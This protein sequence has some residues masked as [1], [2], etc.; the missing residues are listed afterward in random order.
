MS[1][2]N[3]TQLECYRLLKLLHQL[4]LQPPRI[5]HDEHLKAA[6]FAACEHIDE[7]D[8][9]IE[10]LA[11]CFNYILDVL[12][13]ALI[14]G[15]LPHYFRPGVNL[16]ADISEDFMIDLT[17]K[18]SEIR[19]DPL[20]FLFRLNPLT[21]T[22][23]MKPSPNASLLCHVAEDQAEEQGDKPDIKSQQTD[24]KPQMKQPDNASQPDEITM[25]DLF[26]D[27]VKDARQFNEEEKQIL[28]VFKNCYE[29]LILV[30]I[31]QEW[32]NEA[33]ELGEEFIER[34][35]PDTIAKWS[36]LCNLALS[37]LEDL[38][39]IISFLELLAEQSDGEEST[40]LQNLACMY[41]SLMHIAQDPEDIKE[42][43]AKTDDLFKQAM[44]IND[45][46]PALY[47][48]YGNFLVSTN[49]FEN[50]ILI[51]DRA[52]ELRKIDPHHRNGYGKLEINCVDGNM[53]EEIKIFGE[54]SINSSA[55][56]CYLLT[57]CQIQLQNETELAKVMEEFDEICNDLEDSFTYK[58]LGYAYR[59]AQNMAEAAVAFQK[60]LQLEDDPTAKQHIQSLIN[61]LDS[62]SSN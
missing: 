61:S 37:G 44:Q 55:Y 21:R 31:N 58:L 1:T 28:I 57:I 16:L 4:E 43:E 29:K 35:P 15:N 19:R 2:L 22:H 25:L 14:V 8:W 34:L 45:Q 53:V 40:L 7:D 27:V 54:V 23:K 42:I 12:L 36:Y 24:S 33:L 13:H 32:Y 50:A 47:A 52:V 62:Q 38:N 46:S 60:A 59:H 17:T 49:Q 56:A 51:L 6:L 9:N 39:K 18:I 3:T 26:Q 20:K 10:T 30:C 48:D 5:L 41:H 11:K